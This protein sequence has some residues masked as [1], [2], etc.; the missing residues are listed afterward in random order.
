MRAILIIHPEAEDG[1]GK[2]EERESPA[3]QEATSEAEAVSGSP[4][5]DA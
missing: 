3:R 1:Y 5:T 2:S 4:I